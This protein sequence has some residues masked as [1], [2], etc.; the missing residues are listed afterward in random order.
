MTNFRFLIVSFLLVSFFIFQ[1]A[2]AQ[3]KKDVRDIIMSG[4]E[5]YFKDQ[6]S[7][8]IDFYYKAISIDSLN[9]YANYHLAECHRMTFSFGEAEKYYYIVASNYKNEYPLAAFYFPQMQKL[10]GKFDEAIKNF[11]I[12][13]KYSQENDFPEKKEFLEK[14]EIEQRGCYFAIKHLENPFGEYQLKILEEP[15]NSKYNDYG[16]FILDNDS[17]IG[18]TSGRSTVTGKVLNNRYGEYFSDNFRFKADS[19]GW[20][21][22]S[23]D[24]NFNI[25]N[26]EFG[27]GAGSYSRAKDIYYFTGCYDDGSFCKIYRADKKDGK[28]QA[29]VELPSPINLK[30]ADNK[31]PSVTFGGDTLFFVSNRL[32]GYGGSDIWMSTLNGSESWS[33]PVNLGE[34]VNTTYN[35]VSPFYYQQDDILFFASDGH[36]GL[37]GMDIFMA[38]G[39]L[40]NIQSV[41][42]LGYPFNSNHD[43]GYLVLGEKKGY[44]S[45]NREGGLGNFDILQFNIITQQSIIAEVQEQDKKLQRILRSRVNTRSGGEV[46]VMREEDQFFYE[47]LKR[48]EKVIMTKIIAAKVANF[49]SGGVELSL[50]AEEMAF[51]EQLPLLDRLRLD[52][53]AQVLYGEG[54]ADLG[55]YLNTLPA[56]T[57]LFSY[58]TISGKLYGTQSN[59]PAPGVLIPLADESG[60]IV[61]ETTTNE[62]GTFK[63]INLA[64]NAKYK[65]LAENIPKK[66]TESAKFYIRDLRI[67]EVTKEPIVINFEDIYFD[68]DEDEL[69]P[70]A[71]MV[72]SDLVAYYKN[73]PK[74]QIEIYAF[75][76]TTGSDEYNLQL[77]RSRGKAAYDYLVAAKIDRSSLVFEALGKDVSAFSDIDQVNLQL[78]RRVE[79]GIVGATNALDSDVR[80]YI[81]KK[82]VTLE[83][84]AKFSGN[85]IS[86]LRTLNG[87]TGNSIPAYTP[88]RIKSKEILEYTDF[89][90]RLAD[91]EK[92]VL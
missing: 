73:N 39:G 20:V 69:R 12:F 66:L 78:N 33:I 35:E 59:K 87:I 29:A 13:I 16:P 54:K 79:F 48:D 55:D 15:I 42:N 2:N 10:N 58:L 24:D 31:Q 49:G 36:E 4:N 60:N 18:L 30:G 82:K 23:L 91:E 45:S 52:R 26:T 88:V 89:L 5:Y 83:Q 77:S 11:D 44:F 51:Y 62:D 70:E 76:D 46:Y 28:W 63:Y 90:Y 43:D 38:K 8:A 14:A 27:E 84:L 7:K 75:T 21:A 32:G 47:D 50:T 80:T 9:A 53:M 37:G 71:K 56:R 65:I 41:E 72:L 64:L 3:K 61:K 81:A 17:T 85:S 74:I 1:E 68:V 67:Q 25:N 34:K 92:N 86:D 40:T 19:V 6:F 57:T 22:T